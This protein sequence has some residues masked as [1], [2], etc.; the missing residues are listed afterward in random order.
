MVLAMPSQASFTPEAAPLSAEAAGPALDDR[1]AFVVAEA[2][3]RT[4]AEVDRDLADEDAVWEAF[5]DWTGRDRPPCSSSS[6]AWR[7]SPL[8]CA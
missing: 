4:I 7:T 6:A 5:T 8:T 3:A 2:L 1:T